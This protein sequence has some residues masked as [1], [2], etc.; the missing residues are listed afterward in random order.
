MAGGGEITY[1][2]IIQPGH[3]QISTGQ[4]QARVEHDKAQSGPETRAQRTEANKS[5]M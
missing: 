1:V 4:T 5:G 3:D 2:P